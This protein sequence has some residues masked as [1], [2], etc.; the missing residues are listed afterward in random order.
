MTYFPDTAQGVAADGLPAASALSGSDIVVLR[1]SGSDVQTTLGTL[2]TFLGVATVQAPGAPGAPVQGSTSTTTI[3][4][5]WAAPSAGGAPANYVL[6]Q[7]A[8]G[9]GSWAT[10]ATPSGTSATV[11]GLTAGTG[12]DFRVAGANAGGTGSYSSTLVNALTTGTLAAPNT[13][14]GLAVSAASASTITLVWTESGGPPATRTVTYRGTGSGPYVAVPGGTFGVTGGTVTGLGASTAYDF[15]VV[16]GNATGTG[17]TA[18]LTNASTTVAAPDAV[19]ALAKG[20]VSAS[21]AVL[22]WTNAAGATGWTVTQRT[23]SGSGAYAAATLS[24]A[25]GAAGATV[26]GLAA[27]SSYDFHVVASNA[28]GN[29]PPATLSGVLTIPA[30]VTALAVGTIT[31]TTVGLTW[32]NATGATAWTVTQRTPSGSGSYLASSLSVAASATGATVS[33]LS[34]GSS[35]DFQVVAGNATGSGAAATLMGV[36]PMTQP[37]GQVTSVKLGTPTS[38]IMPITWTAPG[39]GA[40]PTGYIVELSTN[41]GT[42]FAA[43]ITLN[44]TDIYYQ[45]TGLTSSTSYVARVTAFN[46]NGNGAASVV[47]AAVSTLASSDPFATLS[48]PPTAMV[49]VALTPTYTTNQTAAYLAISLGGSEWGPSSERTYQ[50]V[51]SAGGSLPDAITFPTPG[52]YTVRLYNGG[53]SVLLAESRPIVVGGTASSHDYAVTVGGT[54]YTVTTVPALPTGVARNI[55]TY[56]EAAVKVTSSGIAQTSGV[57]YQWSTSA[58]VQNGGLIMAASL[59]PDGYLHMHLDTY[60]GNTASTR[61]LWMY[62]NSTWVAVDGTGI[63]IP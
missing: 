57:Y 4:L 63:V 45:A 42:S 47:S 34:T 27:G 5:T 36:I 9:A 31:S 23:P 48:V 50:V 13:V 54:A 10:V 24:L 52:T 25:A 38:T 26:S 43:P 14:T 44:S 30:A 1:Q 11:S 7:S 46:D 3:S 61:Y 6:Q 12:Y 20:A 15:Q 55:Q 19:T 41:G 56:F 59:A 17:G 21:T 37:V 40:A 39:G 28:G 58:T 29:G 18:T 49:G 32:S 33:G 53:N 8:T 22:T 62:I 16:E 51:S 2:Q 60:T 35:Y